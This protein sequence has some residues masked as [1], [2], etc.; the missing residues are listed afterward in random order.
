M[1]L[2][3]SNPINE[4][5]GKTINFDTRRQFNR[6][7]RFFEKGLYSMAKTWFLIAAKKNHDEAMNKLGEM[8]FKGLGT[9]IDLHQ[10]HYF[11][12]QAALRKNKQ[13]CGYLSAV[14]KDGLGVTKNAEMA[15]YWEA[16][17]K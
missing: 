14:Y 4:K 10:A 5:R 8:Y 2:V 3:L 6:G 16:L 9:D 1:N 13:A 11:W 17:S 7:L 15:D 12:L